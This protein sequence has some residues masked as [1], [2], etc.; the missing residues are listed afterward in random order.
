MSAAF[1]RLCFGDPR[2][3]VD[4][5]GGRAAPWGS[6]TMYHTITMPAQALSTSFLDTFSI[7]CFTHSPQCNISSVIPLLR[8]FKGPAASRGTLAQP[9][10]A[11]PS[12]VLAHLSPS[13]PSFQFP[14]LHYVSHRFC[15]GLECPSWP[16][17]VPPLTCP[18]RARV[19]RKA[20]PTLSRRKLLLC[21]DSWTYYM[22]AGT[23]PCPCCT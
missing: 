16:F 7:Q 21:L 18:S 1:L 15:V 8:A 4:S 22:V 2:H 19:S 10:T 5:D 17:R 11:F 12:L 3:V 9:S 23:S 20:F 13:P 6:R 14:L